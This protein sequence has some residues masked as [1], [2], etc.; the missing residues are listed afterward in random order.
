MLIAICES[1]AKDQEMLRA[2]LDSYAKIMH[3]SPQFIAVVLR[4]ADVIGFDSSRIPA[5][6]FERFAASDKASIREWKTHRG[7]GSKVITPTKFTYKASCSHPYI[8]YA[9]RQF[10]DVIDAELKESHLTLNSIADTDNADVSKYA[11]KLPLSVDRTNIGPRINDATGKAEYIYS[12]TGFSLD[13]SKI[14]SLLTGTT[15]YKDSDAAIRELLQNSIDACKQMQMYKPKPEDY[16]PSI[17]IKLYED[18]GNEYI[19]VADN[20]IGMNRYIIDNYYVNKGNS[21]YESAEFKGQMAKQ[22]VKK[23]EPISQFGIGI[24][25]TFLISDSISIVTRR[26]IP[27]DDSM[28]DA[29]KGS[30]D[31]PLKVD[32]KGHENF[33]VLK[34]GEIDSHGTV[35]TLRIKKH[36]ENGYKELVPHSWADVSK[37]KSLLDIVKKYVVVPPFPITVIGD[38]VAKPI[39]DEVEEISFDGY[40]P[41][42]WALYSSG[43]WGYGHGAKAEEFMKTIRF[44]INDIANGI[45]GVAVIAYIQ[46][47]RMPVSEFKTDNN[48]LYYKDEAYNLFCHN[49][50]IQGCRKDR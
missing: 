7:I 43:L 17:S 14:I 39:S 46:Q 21:Y 22:G 38:K 8:E 31:E 20:G 28:A 44:A 37:G 32:I 12:E 4:L 24:L 9:V 26:Y 25:S 5:V 34:T 15:L 33:L 1:H 45:E 41:N 36:T 29:P 10:C 49:T 42:I 6:L 23:F 3:C 11:L 30:L 40:E 47:D 13:K 50:S 16:E 2:E 18:D 35:T 19:E 48:M 27:A